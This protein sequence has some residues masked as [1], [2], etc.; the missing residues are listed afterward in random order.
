MIIKKPFLKTTNR[1]RF[2]ALRT[3]VM[4]I[5]I[6]KW[7][8]VIYLLL[9]DIIIKLQIICIKTMFCFSYSFKFQ[10]TSTCFSIKMCHRID[11]VLNSCY[12]YQN[13]C[14]AAWF[15]NLCSNINIT[16]KNK[17]NTRL[18]ELFLWNRYDL[19]KYLCI[20]NE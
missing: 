7:V 13:Q 17:C 10:I 3:I 20:A 19:M 5:Q 2:N 18:F 16:M 1:I 9:H 4:W 11:P 8:Q 14:K 15:P 6:C 12:N